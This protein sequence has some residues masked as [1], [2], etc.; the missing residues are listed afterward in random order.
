[1]GGYES[2]F[3][4]IT[5]AFFSKYKHLSYSC[6]IDDST[7]IHSTS[8][9]K[10]K[11]S[12]ILMTKTQINFRI[13]QD[14]LQIVKEVAAGQGIGYTDWIINQCKISL[15]LIPE[16]L[17]EGRIL[18]LMDMRLQPLEEEVKALSKRVDTFF[19]ENNKLKV[20]ESENLDHL[21]F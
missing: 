20:N 12:R 21:D 11:I 14:L 15:N 9:S 4:S 18:D 3:E 1:M 7:V 10:S 19:K 5:I 2:I 13:D 17:S 16:A 6:L 8:S